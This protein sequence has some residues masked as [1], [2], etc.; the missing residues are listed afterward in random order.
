[1]TNKQKLYAAAILLAA[2]LPAYAGSVTIS[3][4]SDG[5]LKAVVSSNTSGQLSSAVSQAIEN[6][7]T[8]NDT[9]YTVSNISSL[10]VSGSLSYWMFDLSNLNVSMLTGDLGDDLSFIW[11]L[12]ASLT[13]LDLADVTMKPAM[14]TGDDSIDSTLNLILQALNVIPPYAF[15]RGVDIDTDLLPDASNRITKL[16]MYNLKSVKLPSALIGLDA[17]MVAQ[18]ASLIKDY[19]LNNNIEDESLKSMLNTIADT[20]LTAD[21]VDFF[22]GIGDYAFAYA[23]SLES[24]TIPGRGQLKSV[25]LLMKV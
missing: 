16:G 12:R 24:V 17:E 6:Y 2:S 23:T 3:P 20:I 10:K 11:T 9:Q 15:W 21:N 22:G 5:S 7:N 4:L 19:L 13:D 25:R 1:M 14:S 8:S 18:V